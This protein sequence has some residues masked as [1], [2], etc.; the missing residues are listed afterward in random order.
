MAE[1]PVCPESVR[2]RQEVRELCAGSIRALTGQGELHFRGTEL[3]R[4]HR[5]VPMPAPHLHPSFGRAD[6]ASFRGAGDGMALRLLHTDPALHRSLYPED[7]P[8]RL[9]FETLEQFRVESLAAGAWDGVR[10][11]LAHRF[12]RWSQEFVASGLTETVH[13]MLLFTVIQ[14]CRAR[15]TA[16]P[17][18]ETTQDLIESTRFGLASVLGD[19]LPQ[20][21][22]TRH[23]Q[24]DFA[25]HALAVA[26]VIGR[27]LEQAADADESDDTRR[28]DRAAT[29]SLLFDFEPD[30][31]DTFATAASGHSRALGD[32]GDGYRVFT[33]AYDET[34]QITSLVRPELLRDFRRRLDVGIEDNRLNVRKLGRQLKTLLSEPD[35]DGWEGGRDEGYI[36]GRRLAQLVTSPTERR[37]F[38]AERTEPRNDATVTFLIDCS[39]SMKKFS[40]PVAVLVDVFARALELADARCEILGFTTTAW[41]GGRAR[42]DWLRSGRP[43]DPGRLN[44]V[45]QLVFKDA[46]TTWR[47]ARPAIAG[48]LKDDLFKEGVDGEAVDWACSRMRDRGPGRRLLFVISDGSPLDGATALAN[49]EFYLD[50]HLQVVVERHEDE[51][52]VE[53]YG[54]GVGLDLSP[55]YDRCRT[56]DL[57]HGTNS[58]VIA[59]VLSMIA[60]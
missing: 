4:G 43:D 24:S 16:E 49:D 44:E 21:R 14:M 22:R 7:T 29:F 53:V 20:L 2:R 15:I 26:D 52:A 57:T 38:R 42:R 9:I 13:G 3:H 10:A 59:D 48:L 51:R 40:E 37:L 11:N 36:D 46:E 8:S 23:S 30:E 5:R 31:N 32:G 34:R 54:L 35:R 27:R 6:V 58:D 18:P 12:S 17:I 55:Y 60:H 50:H 39:G 33:R 47:R 45:R 56:L 1:L 19:Q 25:V 28:D 41:N